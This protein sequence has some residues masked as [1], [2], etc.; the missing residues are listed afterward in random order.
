MP[1]CEVCQNDY[2]KAFEIILA[3]RRHV[4]DFLFPGDFLGLD[5]FGYHQICDR[6]SNTVCGRPLGFKA[7]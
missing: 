6:R 2:D 5:G 4:F 7:V 3:G 1:V